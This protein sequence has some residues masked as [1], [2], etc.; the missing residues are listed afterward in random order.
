MGRK[1]RDKK[2]RPGSIAATSPVAAASPASSASTE[3][4]D[5]LASS[6]APRPTPAPARAAV[7]GRG[8]WPLPPRAALW[9]LAIAAA[10][11]LAYANAVDTPFLLDDPINIVKNT[12]IQK[13]LDLVLLLRDPRALVSLTLRWNWMLGGAAV[14][15]YHV[16]NIAL[17]AATGW[18][19]YALAFAILRRGGE[20][21][22]ADRR[23]APSRER[24]TELLAATAALVFVLHPVQTESV[25]YVIQ[26]AEIL[27]SAAFVGAMLAYD[28]MASGAGRGA[29]AALAASCVVGVYSKPSFAVLPALLVVQD[30][31]FLSRGNLRAMAR[32][33]PALALAAAAAAATFLLT[34]RVGSFESP[35]AGFDI[36]G[37][38]PTAYLAAQP[39]VLVHYLRV[40]LWPTDLCF[41]CGYR[42]AWPV[43]AT[44]LGDG[45]VLPV[46]LLAALSLSSLAAWKRRPALPFAVFAS[47]VVLA[48]TSSFVPLA[49]FYVEHRLYLAV[50]FLAIALVPPA[51]TALRA[52]LSRAG[53]GA[54]AMR[55]ARASTAAVVLLALAAATLARNQLLGDPIAMMEDS[56]SKAPAN[57]RVQYNLANAY[58]RAGRFDDAI[59]HYE[60]AIRLIPGVARS[61]QNLGSLHLEQGRAEK[62]LEVFEAGAAAKPEAAVAHRN[63]A[64]ALMALGRYDEAL[65]KCEHAITLEP[66]NP[67]GY[68]GAGDALMRLGR[69]G[70]AIAMWK[71]GLVEAPGDAVLR[72]RLKK[73]GAS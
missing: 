23:S 15:G 39:G 37:I 62:A 46:V 64:N 43:H 42:G 66:K 10:T 35:T 13:P 73:A 14:A 71:R 52:A 60:E 59:R 40:V 70:E 12:K 58:K 34:A 18:L 1:A 61:Y 38:S 68:R 6:P 3:G 49:D 25:T 4:N 55:A 31:C 36:E 21:A 63:V 69:R 41:D 16:L 24:D 33:W 44:F 57:E 7:G 53:L 32:R 72:E 9:A 5:S 17:H 56:L 47:A 67:N 26:R 30:L 22:A 51:D 29:M 45:V 65:A 19:V 8:G 11:G 28:A 2:S 20:P 48:P 27:V 54:A 50:A